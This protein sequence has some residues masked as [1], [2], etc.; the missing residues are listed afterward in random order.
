MVHGVE[1]SVARIVG[2]TIRP[3]NALPERFEEFSSHHP[4]NTTFAFCDGSVRLISDNID[5]HLFQSLGT[6][7][8]REIC[9]G[10]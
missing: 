10:Y 6:R 2:S 1:H 5:I 3:P 9:D 8:G 4:N 7:A